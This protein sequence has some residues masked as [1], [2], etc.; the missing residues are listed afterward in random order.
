MS[1]S[2]SVRA[3]ASSSVRSRFM[4]P[5][6]GRGWPTRR[7]SAAD[8]DL[9]RLCWSEGRGRWARMARIRPAIEASRAWSFE[10]AGEAMPLCYGNDRRCCERRGWLRG[11]ESSQTHRWR[12]TDSNLRSPVRRICANTRDCRRSRAPEAQIAGK[13]AKCRFGTVGWS[14]PLLTRCGR[15]AKL[16]G[17]CVRPRVCAWLDRNKMGDPRRGFSL[18]VGLIRRYP[19]RLRSKSALPR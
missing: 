19:L 4:T 6:G 16:A 13:M 11:T 2:S 10:I 3:A 8:K 18:A 5:I 15:S 7:P 9:R 17:F 14:A 12:E 1:C